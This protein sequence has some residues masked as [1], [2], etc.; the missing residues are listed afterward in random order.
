MTT[1]PGLSATEV[2][3]LEVAGATNAAA[4]PPSRTL[5]SIARTNLFNFF[6]NILFA[7]GVALIVLGRWNDAATSVGLGLVNAL[8]GFAQEVRAKRKLDAIQLLAV[9]PATVARDGQATAVAPADIV[10]GD[11]ISLTPGEQVLVDGEVLDGS[12]LGIDESMLTG[13][14]DV[15]PKRAGDTVHSGSFCATGEGWYRATA[16]GNNTYASTLTLSAREFKVSKTPLQQRINVVVRGVTLLVALMSF[17]ILFQAVLNSFS[18]TKIVQ[19]SAVLSGQVPYGLFFV[20][21]LAYAAG[22]AT[23]AKRGALVQQTNAVESLSNVDTVCLDKTG[24]LTANRLEVADVMTF[25][26]ADEESVRHLLGTFARSS[27]SPNATSG[28]LAAGLPGEETEDAVEVPFQS[29]TKWSAQ[30]L[31]SWVLGEHAVPWR[32]VV[33]GAPEILAPLLRADANPFTDATGGRQQATNRG[34]VDGADADLFADTGEGSAR[35]D[36]WAD[37]GLRVLLVATSPEG[38]VA[39]E[40]DGEQA[41]YTPRELTP[42]ALVA[43]RDE[44]RP[45]ALTTLKTLQD[46][47]IDLKIISGDS[48]RTVAAL[49][50]QAGLGRDLQLVTGP[51]LD[52]MS[53]GEFADA[54]VSA[55]IFGRATPAHKERLV[56]ALQQRGRYV[57]M[58][59]DGTNDALSLKRSDV[60]VA[61]ES[62]S[63]VTR[64][65][66]DVVLLQDSFGALSPAFVEGRRINA[67]LTR[68]LYL[69]IARVLTSILAIVFVSMI[70]LGFPY[71]P[72]Q[73]ALTVFTVGIPSLLLTRWARPEPPVPDLLRRLAR[74]V[75]PAGIVTAIIGTVIYAYFYKL[76]QNGITSSHVPARAVE[77]WSSYTGLNFGDP[78][79]ETATAT[80]VAQSALSSFVTFAAFGLLLFIEPPARFFTGWVERVSPDKRPAWLALVLTVVM[81]V[82]LRV[83]ALAGYFG[84]VTPGFRA[85]EWKVYAG[86]LIVWFF[87]LRTL[88]RRRW[89]DKFLGIDHP[90][91]TSAGAP[92]R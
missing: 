70:G 23:I 81:L 73:V 39:P 18:A 75:L 15:I 44:L 86:A 85:P 37:E 55:T 53:D 43:L 74:F 88:W 16:V 72:S 4:A 27:R 57:A 29:A 60:G 5:W 82:V 91:P 63:P 45:H 42:L 36:A 21:A 31:P 79:F 28:A 7:I 24:T 20:I 3:E 8:I 34:I 6:N 67:A 65:V 84:M 59:G 54:A 19:V 9:H 40:H 2:R 77:R 58:L 26:G 32:T 90:D 46:A 56:G 12:S 83:D 22:A 71:E 49:A 38:I 50:R 10:L 76:I 13:E 1:P 25:G 14:V 17:A 11:V 66:A 61:M 48:P 68:S 30:S 78:G 69:F 35:L 33:L 92:P 41:A 80:I 62:G 89:F 87:L 47:G 51:E 52:A 64:N